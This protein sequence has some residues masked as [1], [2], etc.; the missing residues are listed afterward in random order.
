MVDLKITGYWQGT[1]FE[2]RRDIDLVLTPD[3][4]IALTS[5]PLE[6]LQQALLFYVYTPKGE[7]P[8]FPNLGSILFEIMHSKLTAGNLKRI[9]GALQRDLR[10]LFPDL[11]DVF[12]TASVDPTDRNR[13]NITVLAPTNRRFD[14]NIDPENLMKNFANI[15]DIF[16]W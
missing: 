6:E 5:D 7:R 8:A 4:D 11:K 2:C 12:I 10:L 16:R 15:Q 13:V 3:G 9:S 14:I 1:H